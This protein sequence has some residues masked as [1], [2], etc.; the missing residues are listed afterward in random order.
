MRVGLYRA[1]TFSQSQA[2]LFSGLGDLRRSDHGGSV[3]SFQMSHN[4]KA[5]VFTNSG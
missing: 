3:I 4:L 1:R 5:T 2:I